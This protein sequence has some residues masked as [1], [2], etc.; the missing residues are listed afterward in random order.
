[1]K[2][3]LISAFTLFVVIL[4]MLSGLAFAVEPQER[5]PVELTPIMIDSTTMTQAEIN[6][7]IERQVYAQIS[8]QTGIQLHRV[9][10]YY[11]TVIFPTQRKTVDAEVGNQVP[12]GYR[13]PTGGGFFTAIME[14]RK[15][16][17][18]FL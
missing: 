9:Q 4:S 13:F 17:S 11:T 2:K 14:G 5:V 3:R 15:L 12:G 1:M 8:E 16:R 7:E 6:K 10:D 18:A